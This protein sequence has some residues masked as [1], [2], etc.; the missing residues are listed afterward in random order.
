MEISLSDSPKLINIRKLSGGDPI[1]V[2]FA[3]TPNSKTIRIRWY[4]NMVNHNRTVLIN[5]RN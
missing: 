5:K 3:N 4:T 1:G 2:S